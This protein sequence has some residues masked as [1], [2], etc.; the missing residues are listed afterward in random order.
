M[1]DYEAEF[2]EI[3]SDEICG[4]I[5]RMPSLF[6]DAVRC[7][8]ARRSSVGVMLVLDTGE[9]LAATPSVGRLDAAVAL[10]S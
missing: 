4:P 8:G 3:T 7:E 6:A 2:G 1:A 9:L 10:L 5:A